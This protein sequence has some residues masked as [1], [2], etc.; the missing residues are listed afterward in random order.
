VTRAR[1]LV[2][3]VSGLVS[4]VSGMSDGPSM[5]VSNLSK[6]YRI[7]RREDQVSTTAEAV[8]KRVGEA[9]K[10]VKFDVL[11]D[12]SFEQMERTSPT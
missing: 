1:S 11:H 2:S 8:L 3:N 6:T 10:V 5:T 12:A 9:K 7:L 4:N